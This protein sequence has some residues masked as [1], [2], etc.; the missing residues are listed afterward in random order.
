ASH[1]KRPAALGAQ[2]QVDISEAPV[3]GSAAVDP[4]L[5]ALRHWLAETGSEAFIIPTDDPHLS[6]YTA[7][8]FNRRQFLSNFSGS[9]GTAVVTHDKALLWTDGRYFLQAEAE[10]GPEWS[11]MKAGMPDTPKMSDWLTDHIKPGSAVSLD[12]FVHSATFANDLQ[13]ALDKKGLK[14]TPI[15]HSGESNPVDAI[16]SGGRPS[17][18]SAALRLHP[19]KFAGK[20]ASEKIADLR[21]AMAK[22]SADGF[23]VGMLDEVGY[24]MNVRG[25][26]IEC[27]PVTVAYAFV[28][29]DRAVL[30]VDMAKV[31]DLVAENLKGEGIEV[32]PYEAALEAVADLAKQ[33]KKIW[34]DPARVNSAFQN[35][36]PKENRI[37][38]A[39]PVNAAKAIK[40]AAELEGMR[41]AHIRDGAAMAEF[42]CWLEGHIRGGGSI[43]EV[44]LDEH[45]LSYR[46]KKEGFLDV[47]FPTIAGAGPNGAIIHYRAERET[48][49]V[50]DSTKML[51]LDSGA[52]Y[53]DGTTDVTRTM[54][55][56][57]ATQHQREAFTRVLQ[58]NIGIDTAVFPE[59]TPGVLLDA[60]AR[61]SL[62]AAGLDYAHGTG[63]GVGAALNVH[64]GPHSISPR[65]GNWTPLKPGMIVS[66]E[67]GYYEAG[68]FGIRIENL[69]EVS[70]TGVRNEELGRD[71]YRF[72]PLTLIPIQK[73][74]LVLELMHDE[75]IE[76]LNAYHAKV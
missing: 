12:P 69:L 57:E 18:P 4:K 45:L 61:K 46:S 59:G 60:F 35:V 20:P 14:L 53:L 2:S 66:N 6:E 24:L 16:W 71:F 28:T 29:A 43:S 54:H 22:E 52:Q 21:E 51:L 40:N 10:L 30:F 39:S 64:E 15:E 34:V 72:E 17:P 48:C 33:G 41:N 55:F 73:D 62:W 32:Q 9:A 23:V 56:G 63:H 38:T 67:P 5:A 1:S 58:G 27:N 50:L 76:W 7:A 47:S 42:F 11:L 8:C 3:N 75:E 70:A 44:E 26:D 68:G 13:D 31:P 65:P 49:G 74:L 36:V 37:S 25:A 19:I